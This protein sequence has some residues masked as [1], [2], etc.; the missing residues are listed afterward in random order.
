[1][2]EIFNFILNFI[3]IFK[4]LISINDKR[5]FLNA[6]G[7]MRPCCT[8]SIGTIWVDYTTVYYETVC[9]ELMNE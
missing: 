9:T 2:N 6:S 3:M 5:L 1:M 7:E 4:D 8:V